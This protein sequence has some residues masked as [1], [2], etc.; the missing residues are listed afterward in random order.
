MKRLIRYFSELDYTEWT[1]RVLIAII[2][3][4]VAGTC[5]AS[6]AC[7]PITKGRPA[8]RSGF[9][10]AQHRMYNNFNEW[11]NTPWYRLQDGPDMIPVQLLVADNGYGCIV[12]AGEWVLVQERAQ[13]HCKDG[14]RAP[15]PE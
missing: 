14:W 7:S 10:V 2:L 5:F 6:V 8:P 13:H 4:M 3:L 15:R 9:M 11:T 1:E 12:E